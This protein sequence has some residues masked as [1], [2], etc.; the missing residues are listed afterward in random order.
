MVEGGLAGTAVHHRERGG[1]DGRT[2]KQCH[3]SP[4][5]GL[6]QPDHRPGQRLPEHGGEEHEHRGGQC[7]GGQVAAQGQAGDLD[8]EHQQLHDPHQVE[9]GQHQCAEE[10]RLRAYGEG[11]Q[12]FGGHHLAAGRGERGNQGQDG[13]AEE[14][15]R[16]Q[17]CRGLKGGG[18]ERTR[19]LQGQHQQPPGAQAGEAHGQAYARATRH[20]PAQRQQRKDLRGGAGHAMSER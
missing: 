13:E 3:P 6:P 20:L 15:L 14:S 12:L 19:G 1:H 4:R 10:L 17:C 2:R 9:R 5:P 16:R 8:A 18:L 11:H 7:S